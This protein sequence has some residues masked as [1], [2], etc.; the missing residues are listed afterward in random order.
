[1]IG[2][3]KSL[4]QESPHWWQLCGSGGRTAAGFTAGVVVSTRTILC[5]SIA[6]TLEYVVPTLLKMGRYYNTNM[7]HYWD[8]LVK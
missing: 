4:P 7:R 8:M 6:C 1:M 5:A 3:V 2:K